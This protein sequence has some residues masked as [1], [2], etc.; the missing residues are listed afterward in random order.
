[1]TAAPPRDA[2]AADRAAYGKSLR[3]AVPR[4]SHAGWDP[5]SNRP[6]PVTLLERQA[7]PRVPE[8][9]PIRYERMLP[10]PM[11]FFRGAA[12]VMASDLATTPAT[13]I[14]VQLSGDAHLSNFGGFGTPERDLVFDLNDFDETLPGPWEWDI[15][16][17]AVSLELAGRDLGFPRHRRQE[18]VRTA[19]ARY[20]EDIRRLAGMNAL[21]VWYER[22]RAADLEAL[23]HARLSAKDAKRVKTRLARARQKGSERAFEKLRCTTNGDG[24]RIG[25]DP[26]LLVP[27]ADLLEAADAERLQ[28][29][30]GQVLRAY[31]S[32]LPN[33]RKRLFDRF[34]FADMAR[35]VG[36]V[37]SVG[38][39]CWAVLMVG[40][41]GGEPL[42]LQ[43]KE[44]ER[45]VLEPFAGKS[46]FD[47]QGQRVVEGQRLIQGSADIFLGWLRTT[48]I[49]GRQ[50]DF[51]IRQLWDW[52]VSAQVE[53]MNASVLGDYGALCASTLARAHARSGDAMAIGAYLGS[54]HAFDSALADFAAAY[55]DQTER[56]HRALVDAAD[57]GRVE[58]SA[59]G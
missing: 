3:G 6:D 48:G 41:D 46:R 2:A 39:R 38:T 54:G 35:R 17:L 53:T 15:K 58:G 56:D 9:V 11:T 50:R 30:M 12:Y 14:R 34:E 26:P 8:L 44:A 32:S 1:V 24:P 22:T 40:R 16:R 51:Y 59:V 45:S 33:D 27:V 36:G 4:S 37:G 25:A 47:N 49:D 5:G 13:G 20:R 18:N 28:E 55:A 21:E 42:F 43:A 52:K 7:A 31:R 29:A 57:N 19:V 23:A 10:T